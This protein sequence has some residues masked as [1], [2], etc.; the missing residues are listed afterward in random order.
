MAKYYEDGNYV[1]VEKND[2]L[3]AIARDYKKQS[4]G[5]TYTQLAKL[6]NIKNA[7]II[8]I[9]QKIKLTDGDD[10]EPESTT[11]AKKDPNILQYGKKSTDEKTLF[12]TWEWSKYKDK[13][14][15]YKTQWSYDTDLSKG[16]YIK[17]LNSVSVD[18]DAPEAALYDEFS[19]PTGAL[20][21]KFKVLPIA[22]SK[23]ENNEEV[24]E[25][26]AK[27]S[28]EVTFNNSDV[29]A[30][31]KP[32]SAPS[33]EVVDYKFVITVEG[34]DP[35]I[36]TVDFR[37]YKNEAKDP[38]VTK[39]GVTVINGIASYTRTMTAGN[40]YRIQYRVL[41]DGIASEWSELSDQYSTIPAAPE[42]ITSCVVSEYSTAN[43]KGSVTIKWTSVNAANKIPGDKVKY[44]VQYTDKKE[45][46]DVSDQPTTK[47]GI[48]T[49]EYIIAEL[50]S[51]KEYFFRVRATNDK[52]NSAWTEAVSV[53]IGSVPD[54]PTT[55][56]SVTTAGVGDELYLYWVHNSTDNSYQEYADLELYVDDEKIITKTMYNNDV[57]DDTV[58]TYIPL[59]TEQL[60]QGMTHSCLIKTAQYT[61]GATIKWAIRTAGITNSYG[62]FSTQRTIDVYP[63]PDFEYRIL[64]RESEPDENG[65]YELIDIDNNTINTFPFYIYARVYEYKNQQPIGYHVSIE[66]KE[67]YETVDNLGN[68]KMVSEGEHVYS[69]YFDTNQVLQIELNPANVS[70]ENNVEYKVSCTVSMNSG[71]SVTKTADFKV[72]WTANRYEPNAVVGIDRDSLKASIRPYCVEYNNV[73]K[74][75]EQTENGYELTDTALDP[76]YAESLFVKTNAIINDPGTTY[77]TGDVTETG[78]T[79]YEYISNNNIAFYCKVGSVC[80]AVEERRFSAAT[81]T[82]E[83]VHFSTTSGGERVYFSIVTEVTPIT[84]VVMSVYRREFDGGF[85]EIATDLDGALNTTVTDPHPSLDYARYRIVAADKV[86]GTVGYNDLSGVA[87]SEPAVVI[88]WDEEWTS[89][90]STEEGELEQPPWSGS[91][92]KLR[93][94]IDT[95]ENVDPEVEMIEYIGRSNPVSYYGTQRRQSATWNVVI[96]KSDKE[97][98]YALRRLANWMGDVYVREPSGVGYWAHIVVSFN[99]TH[100]SVTIPVTLTITRVEGGM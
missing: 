93:Y 91:L 80:Y 16:T 75:V 94:N 72:G 58:M 83:Q 44:D 35:D 73:Y 81:T 52:G 71:L 84:D 97:T 57:I 82:G 2:T 87:I 61:E 51:G 76:M 22:E 62:K 14:A 39:N 88:Q 50:E 42:K 24:F 1:I 60:E 48:E 12:A 69:K 3:S 18:K 29:L 54:A 63:K 30:P 45:Y 38:A 5:K 19:I 79:I 41:R 55:W 86:T 99:Q 90:D 77:E 26:T 64:R 28:E 46:F 37:I 74:K 21:V 15:S 67:T 56:S 13:T 36:T 47:T 25:W 8:S 23:T 85:T 4:V 9:G 6:N 43:K 100:K 78:E 65:V 68:V 34:L 96:E 59:T 32:T 89:F 17:K 27:W 95:S 66:S 11:P 53:I 40:S 10:P 92:L 98:V 31:D 70:L 33:V 20:H 7:N 49:N